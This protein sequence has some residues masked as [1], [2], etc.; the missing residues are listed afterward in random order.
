MGG[1]AGGVILG[2]AAYM[3]PEQALGNLV[4]KRTADHLTIENCEMSKSL[5][6]LIFWTWILTLYIDLRTELG[7]LFTSNFQWK[8]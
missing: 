2:T 6:V 7:N 3:S 8:L 4:D 1:T 5:S